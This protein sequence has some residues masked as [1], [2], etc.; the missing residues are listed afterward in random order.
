MAER[1]GSTLY[2]SS[3]KRL[4]K[5]QLRQA[6]RVSSC[7][8][9]VARSAFRMRTF[10]AHGLHIFMTFAGMHLKFR[11]GLWKAIMSAGD[12]FLRICFR[13]PRTAWVLRIQRR[14]AKTI[15]EVITL[16]GLLRFS[17]TYLGEN[18]DGIS[19]GLCVH[20]ARGFLVF[21]SVRMYSGDS[22]RRSGQRPVRDSLQDRSSATRTQSL[23]T[24]SFSNIPSRSSGIELDRFA[25]SER[26]KE[27]NYAAQSIRVWQAV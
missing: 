19:R 17:I 20:R 5:Q 27:R 3:T 26:A 8:T 13:C 18:S 11:R 4:T 23:S 12:R 14:T 1:N 15:Q 7:S 2:E 10:Y 6:F 22:V 25:S 16:L 9:A 21:T 24:R